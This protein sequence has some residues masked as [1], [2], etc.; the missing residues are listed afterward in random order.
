MR[1]RI[2]QMIML[3]TAGFLGLT[4]SSCSKGDSE[5]D[6]QKP[7]EFSGYT[8]RSKTKANG[9][10]V[11]ATELPA[12][13]AFGVYVYNTGESTAFEP[14]NIGDYSVFMSDVKVTYTGNGASNPE[15]YTYSPMRYW[16]N[17]KTSNR[18][19]FFAYYPHGGAGIT[20]TGFDDFGFT[21]QDDPANQVD[22]MLSDVVPNQMYDATNATT[23]VVNMSFYHM[24]TQ[25]RF[26]GISD[27][28][29]GV[30]IKVTSL[31]VVDVINSGTL[32][33]DATATA[34][35]WAV[36]T[37]TATYDLTLKDIDLP[38]K[39]VDPSAEAV[40]IAEDNQTLLMV[41]QTLS[42]DAMVEIEYTITTTKPAR[43]ITQTQQVPLKSLIEEWARN[44]QIVYTLNFGIHPIE[45]SADVDDWMDDEY[46]IIVE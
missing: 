18:L 38:N 11:N 21:V 17:S 23:G 45:I 34:S 19:T 20:K 37:T 32:T 41:P 1:F 24:L 31:S 30:A 10:F 43:V 27:A 5:P 16:P 42:E 7:M 15:K 46:I 35:T 6:Y 28:P 25:I 29:S 14:A 9:S 44:Q 36:G 39:T 13:Q 26:K 2:R 40:V 22:F 8:A 12:N 3:M 4:L 33:P